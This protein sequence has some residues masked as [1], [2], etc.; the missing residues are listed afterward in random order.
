MAT[1]EPLLP[2]QAM[3]IE[4]DYLSGVTPV[5]ALPESEMSKHIGSDDTEVIAK[6]RRSLYTLRSLA[7]EKAQIYSVDVEE[8]SLDSHEEG[9]LSLGKAASMPPTS[10]EYATSLLELLSHGSSSFFNRRARYNYQT[11]LETGVEA[12]RFNNERDSELSE[13]SSPDELAF[14]AS[15][16]KSTTSAHKLPRLT[17]SVPVAHRQLFLLDKCPSKP[18]RAPSP[19]KKRS[20]EIKRLLPK[21]EG[22]IANVNNNINRSVDSCERNRAD[23]KKESKNH[24]ANTPNVNRMQ[25]QNNRRS[26]D[27]MKAPRYAKEL[28]FK[29]VRGL[30]ELRPDESDNSD[31]SENEKERIAC[32]YKKAHPT[33]VQ[34]SRATAQFSGGASCSK[35]RHDD[36]VRWSSSPEKANNNSSSSLQVPAR[37]ISPNTAA[38]EKSVDV[39]LDRLLLSKDGRERL[40]TPFV[41]LMGRR[42]EH[43]T[44]KGRAATFGR[45]TIKFP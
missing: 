5:T 7:T 8:K 4:E 29:S 26:T 1:T 9:I 2:E 44:Q 21:K 35:S 6:G 28:A 20:A 25:T 34:H 10:E 41:N 33:I 30:Y 42:L 31:G 32:W 38:K 39:H 15:A 17:N 36:S 27:C 24:P 43:A 18:V 14:S 13:S 40:A 45:P 19:G 3:T 37:S 22:R 23:T 12:V 16:S 11:E